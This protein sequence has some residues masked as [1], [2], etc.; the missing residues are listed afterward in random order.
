MELLDL[1]PAQ[2]AHLCSGPDHYPG[3]GVDIPEVLRGL[4][5]STDRAEARRWAHRLFDLVYHGHSGGYLLPAEAAVPHLIR[6]GSCG[7][8]GVRAVALGFLVDLGT[9]GWSYAESCPGSEDLACR[10]SA[11]VRAGLPVYYAQ[12]ES[13]EAMV[14]SA[15]FVLITVL[16]HEALL[17]LRGDA[18][19]AVQTGPPIT[20]ARYR[21]MVERLHEQD[22]DPMVRRY[23]GLAKVDPLFGQGEEYFGVEYLY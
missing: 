23:L 18:R 13:P 8:A 22:W 5:A 7:P 10:T 14:R 20:S 15:A 12:L 2:W 1:D 3:G 16:E 11:A 21:A 17:E 9:G 4:A 19:I 6:L